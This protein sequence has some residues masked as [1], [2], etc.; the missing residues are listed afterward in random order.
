MEGHRR[1][2]VDEMAQ[3]LAEELRGRITH[4]GRGA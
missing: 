4:W 3:A 1:D 2:R